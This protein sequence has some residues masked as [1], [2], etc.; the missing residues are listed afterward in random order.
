ML[1]GLPSCA[2]PGS[3]LGATATDL[4]LNRTS[5][6]N[7]GFQVCLCSKPRKE[8]SKA[9]M[10]L[11]SGAWPGRKN[12]DPQ[13]SRI[14]VLPLLFGCCQRGSLSMRP[15]CP[16]SQG[17]PGGDTRLWQCPP[18]ALLWSHPQRLWL[19]RRVLDQTASFPVLPGRVGEIGTFS[20]VCSAGGEA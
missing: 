1:L 7:P 16:P 5:S 9:R 3:A 2:L 12:T 17:A 20:E 19:R 13:V 4:S 10:V 14:S 15:P 8:C 18:G 11:T 6:Q